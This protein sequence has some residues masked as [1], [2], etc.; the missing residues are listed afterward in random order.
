MISTESMGAES[1]NCSLN[2]VVV[3]DTVFS[4][5]K[6]PKLTDIQTLRA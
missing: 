1:G 4:E 5:E 6:K 3:Q 2:F